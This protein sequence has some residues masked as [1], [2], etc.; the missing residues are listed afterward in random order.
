LAL[1]IDGIEEPDAVA[2]YAYERPSG[3]SGM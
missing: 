1:V 3:R 2:H